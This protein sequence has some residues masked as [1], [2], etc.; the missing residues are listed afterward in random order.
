MMVA[1]LGGGGAVGNSGSGL[2]SPQGRWQR[3]YGKQRHDNES[4]WE[5]RWHGW[6][7]RCDG[8]GGFV[9]TLS[10]A[11]RHRATL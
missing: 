5:R 11:L 3:L 9:R 1:Q 7:R 6:G 8:G 2:A 10:M 4:G